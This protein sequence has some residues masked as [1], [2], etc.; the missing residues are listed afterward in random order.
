MWVLE[1]LWG[2]ISF[3]IEWFWDY[4]KELQETR[5]IK[6]L[7]LLFIVSLSG[8]LLLAGALIWSL[9]WVIN[10]HFEIV[11]I[12][13]VIAWL[14]AY[15]KHKNDNK[16]EKEVVD[17]SSLELKELEERATK[18]YP[19]MRNI[20]YQTL[21]GSAES[22]GGRI[23]RVLAE[24]EVLE[25]HFVISNNIIFYQ[26]KLEKEDIRTR[27]SSEEISEFKNILQNDIARKIENK[28]FPA[29]SM[30]KIIDSNG[31]IYDAVYIDT[32]EDLDRYFLLQTAFYS[33]QYADYLRIKKM[34]KQEGQVMIE[35][36]EASWKKKP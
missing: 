14:F 20:L 5:N 18:G 17:E 26:F 16:P 13:G 1:W 8:F 28:D 27:Y 15:V 31:N 11:V 33:P 21:K 9:L 32:M 23:P 25:K 7:V 4:Y 10:Y 30:E 34:A 2:I 29:L 36:P 3:P 19:I 22:L 35:I 24:I 6:K 12:I